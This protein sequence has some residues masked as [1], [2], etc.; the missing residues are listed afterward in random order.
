MSKT[1]H[2]GTTE[3]RQSANHEKR[4]LAIERVL[5]KTGAVYGIP[6]LRDALYAA[7]TATRGE[8][9]RN[10]DPSL[11]TTTASIASGGRRYNA[12]Y[13]PG[14]A[15]TGM[16]TIVTTTGSYT[17]TAPNSGA[18]LYTTDGA[19]LTRVA[20]NVMKWTL[21]AGERRIAWTGGPVTLNAQILYVGVEYFASAST[22]VP[23]WAANSVVD[24]TIWGGDTNNDFTPNGWPLTAEQTGTSSP[25]PATVSVGALTVGS[26][27]NVIY[28]GLY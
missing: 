15:C 17:D 19:T 23:Q 27:S 3:A 6:D 16:T 25:L 1:L 12:V 2:H 24:A 13:W 9:C 4:L 8:Q 20:Q 14:G 5:R 18:A 28:C 26:R 21:A 22:T 7:S 10:Y 11:A